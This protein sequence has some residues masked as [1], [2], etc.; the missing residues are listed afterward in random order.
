VFEE[1]DATV[2]PEALSQAEGWF[3]ETVEVWG[4]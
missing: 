4:G 1:V 3:R 2:N